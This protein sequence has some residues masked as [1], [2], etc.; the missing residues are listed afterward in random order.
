MREVWLA[1]TRGETKEGKRMEGGKEG[2]RG[3][4]KSVSRGD[5]YNKFM[6]MLMWYV[7][8]ETEELE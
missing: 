6:N 5:T 1:G 8:I 3:M 4:I 2:E 7:G